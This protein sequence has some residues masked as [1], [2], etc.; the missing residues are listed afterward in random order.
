MPLCTAWPH[1]TYARHK[2]WY[3]LL[4]DWL[5]CTGSYEHI[6][7][8]LRNISHRPHVLTADHLPDCR[9]RPE[10]Y[11]YIGH[12]STSMIYAHHSQT[13][14]G[15]PDS[16]QQADRGDLV[17]SAKTKNGGQSFLIAASPTAWNSL[18][19]HLPYPFICMIPSANNKSDEGWKSIHSIKLTNDTCTIKNN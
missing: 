14:L 19:L 3:T 6:T 11:P 7:P 17:Q 5:L 12:T 16:S 1:A 9:A 10:L 4:L 15:V 2:S 13:C 8:V 18:R